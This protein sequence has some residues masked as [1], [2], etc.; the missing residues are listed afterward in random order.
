MIDRWQEIY[1]TVRR[2]KLRTF[3]TALSVAWGIF[4]LVILLGAGSGLQNSVEYKFRDD[5]VNSIWLYGGKTT[6]PHAGLPPGRKITFKNGDF[7]AIKRDIA[8][9][10][11]ITGRYTMRD[12]MISYRDQ[13]AS[14]Q[15]RSCHPDHLYLENT[16]IIEGRFLNDL[17]L[18]ERRKV[19]V[20]GTE[21]RD[22][23]FKNGEQ[24][25][26]KQ[27]EIG[28]I[29]YR[30]IGV[31]E[32]EGGE[33]ELRKVYIPITTAQRAYGGGEDIHQIM[34]TLGDANVADSRRVEGQVRSL[35]AARHKFSPDDKR[36]LRVRNNLENFAEIN[37]VFTYIR[38]FVW[39]VGIGTII[40][41]IVGVSNIMLISVKERTREI[42]LR[43]A[44]G[45]TPGSLIALILE[46]SILLTA[47]A[48]YCGV[49]AGVGVLELFNRFV[50]ENEYLRNPQVDLGVVVW[51]TVLL[52]FFGALAGFWPAR[53]AARVNPIEALR[54]E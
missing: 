21:V 48:G 15:V 47:V 51:A 34:F 23:L 22:F 11:H 14:F 24:P 20:I 33:R 9:V 39:I 25:M 44:L 8:A 37:E 53:R 41:G 49:V 42:G 46:E 40:A 6:I 43:K 18:A 1:S 10:E 38:I 28:G 2:N 50:P 45:A 30:V 12:A 31:F 4:M 54:D 16:I 36:A 27:I 35:L 3:L 19:T 32:D 29:S 52:V 13:A 17:D 7:D 5:A 26:G